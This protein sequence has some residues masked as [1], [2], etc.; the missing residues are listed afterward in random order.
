MALRRLVGYSQIVFQRSF[1]DASVGSSASCTLAAI[2]RIRMTGESTLLSVEAS[3]LASGPASIALL[4]EPLHALA[5]IVPQA[6]TNIAPMLSP[7]HQL[8][9][10]ILFND[11]SIATISH[12]TTRR[13]WLQ[14]ET[15]PFN[16]LPH[17]AAIFCLEN[18]ETGVYSEEEMTP[19]GMSAMVIGG[20][21][22]HSVHLVADRKCSR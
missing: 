22:L 16:R 20:A 5:N 13:L 10:P 3:V 21:R 4:D 11:D 14:K 19:C 9:R 7:T 6:A 15:A 17:P 8:S 2:I 1:L 18:H 12:A